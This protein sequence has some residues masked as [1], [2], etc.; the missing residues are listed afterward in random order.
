MA[1]FSFDDPK[2]YYSFITPADMLGR[3]R[4]KSLNSV[5]VLKDGRARDLIDL[6]IKRGNAGATILA[7]KQ[8][9]FVNYSKAGG[10]NVIYQRQ[11]T[12]ESDVFTENYWIDSYGKPIKDF[13]SQV[14]GIDSRAEVQTESPNTPVVDFSVILLRSPMLSLSNVSDKDVEFYLNHMPPTFANQLMPYCDVE[15][16]IPRLTGKSKNSDKDVATKNV[17]EGYLNRPSL[18]RFLVG[19]RANLN[20]LTEAD[21]SLA[22]LVK[23]GGINNG[24]KQSGISEGYFTGMEM[25][26][27]PQTLVDMSNLNASESRALDSKPFLPPAT[28]TGVTISNQ[29]AGGG[30]ETTKTATLAFVVHD[31]AR[32][33]EFSEFIRGAPGY[34]D[35]IVWITYGML[36]PRSH[37]PDDAYAKFV[38][39]TMLVREAYT[40]SNPT[41]TFNVDGSVAVN[42]K[43]GLAAKKRLEF[44]QLSSVNSSFKTLI[45]T[46]KDA[47]KN[48]AKETSSFGGGERTE[49]NAGPV[50]IRVAGYINSVAQESR[51]LGDKKK[52]ELASDIDILIK[53]Y[54]EL[55]NGSLERSRGYISSRSTEEEPFDYDKATKLLKRIKNFYGLE[56]KPDGS[57]ILSRPEVEHDRAPIYVKNLFESA[58]D[59]SSPDPFF[60]SSRKNKSDIFVYSPD[61]I[62]VCV[63]TKEDIDADK[64][65]L[66][67]EEAA[68][69]DAKSAN[70]ANLKAIARSNVT[71]QQIRD[72]LN[73]AYIARYSS[74]PSKGLLNILTA[75]ALHETDGGKSMFNYNFGGIK[76][77]K[78]R[79]YYEGA[80]KEVKDGKTV[81]IRD[82][83]RAYS[84]VDEGAADFINYINYNYPEAR[85]AADTGDLDSYVSSLKERGYFTDTLS[86][87]KTGLSRRL[88][89]AEKLSDSPSAT[90]PKIEKQ[91][92]KPNAAAPQKKS[93]RKFVS[94]GKIFSTFCIR[95]ILSS[96]QTEFAT[97][98]NESPVEVQFNFYQLNSQCGPVSSHNIAEFPIDMTIFRE[99]Y[100][101]YCIDIGGEDL[102][103]PEFI[104]FMNT[105]VNDQRNPGYGRRNYY[106]P[107][108]PKKPESA[109]KGNVD[110]QKSNDD[111]WHGR[112]GDLKLPQISVSCEVF[113][114]QRYHSKVDLLHKLQNR[115]AGPYTDPIVDKSDP[116]N[117]IIVRFHI[118]D[119]TANPYEKLTRHLTADKDGN[120]T[121][122]SPDIKNDVGFDAQKSTIEDYPNIEP[123][124]KGNY[125]VRGEIIGTNIGRG[126]NALKSY[127][128]EM[129]PT[130]QIGAEGSL[131]TSAQF[132]SK[133][134]NLQGTV[135]LQGG[136]WKVNPTLTANGLSQEMYNLPMRVMPVQVTLST[137]GCPILGQA[138]RYF[139]DFNTGTTIDNIYQ[140]GS[141]Q[142]N[143][144]P[145]KFETQWTFGTGG[146]GY[147][148][149]QAAGAGFEDLVK[150]LTKDQSK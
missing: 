25:F 78:N 102:T 111:K 60:P 55:K 42:I 95:P 115:V 41:F 72:A 103:I 94:F 39:E 129:I 50:E 29:N 51:V 100:A 71:P 34:S 86:S 46:T 125:K 119:R 79:N 3:T 43:L 68:T 4:L 123:D 27:S 137:M 56:K 141:I 44:A 48:L 116:S 1:S 12:S 9:D 134:D 67:K 15:F 90:A 49:K 64:N 124:E 10:F 75:Q 53:R 104:N 105:Q 97:G 113:E 126:K 96:I 148:T 128:S 99:A 16:Q 8:E 91:N 62:D 35:M 84:N 66:T 135:A 30:T 98:I 132:Q 146:E 76:S 47:L 150:K 74:S 6:L 20:N 81:E 89:I 127:I 18:L 24:V 82:N 109:M 112:W 80:T 85:K 19:S 138:T 33:A 13:F 130:L 36:A 140:L 142:H 52:A 106:V 31:K 107:F 32:L 108:D 144:S 133:T 117:K 118:Y 69:I 22:Y 120:F 61:L 65:V 54:Q 136:T 26:T 101:K 145:G 139:I 149:L 37:G 58:T 73:R 92:E 87:Y 28:L 93:Y 147:A 83:F 57:Y 5:T 45:D 121:V 38:N 131:I 110:D 7:T 21:K 17:G 23:L 59:S 14:C 11:N 122:W 40:V 143:I 114:E 2:S 70:S 77:T 88:A 63:L